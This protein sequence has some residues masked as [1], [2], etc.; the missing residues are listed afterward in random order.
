MNPPFVFGVVPLLLGGCAAPADPTAPRAVQAVAPGA[1][2]APAPLHV[3]AVRAG[4]PATAKPAR[5]QALALLRTSRDPATLRD[6]AIAFSQTPTDADVKILLGFLTD[7]A[8]L[9]RLDPPQGLWD[10]RLTD[11]LRCIGRLPQRQ[12][13][14]ALLQLAKHAEFMSHLGRVLSLLDGLAEIRDPS[15]TLL[16][17]LEKPATPEPWQ[18]EMIV[19]SG[20]QVLSK[21]RSPAACRRIDKRYFSSGH[22]HSTWFT[23]Y[24]LLLRDDPAIV[25][26]YHTLLSRGV[27]DEKLRNLIVESLF[28]YRREWYP[29]TLHPVPRPP[30]RREASPEGL[31]ELLRVADLTDKLRLSE[32][33]KAAVRKARA[34]IDEILPFHR[35]GKPQRIAQLIADLDHKQHSIRDKASRELEQFGDWAAPAIRKALKAS[36]PPSLERQRRLQQILTAIESKKAE[37]AP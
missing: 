14:S 6:A 1:T 17:F 15:D 35:A 32:D 18:A 29:R 7:P 33:T 20:F 2:A 34:E 24:L 11:V 8:F 3:A 36:P 12:A 9:T 13:N 37:K 4:Q 31:T 16:D 10:L 22:L 30:P 27:Q 26:M 21:M 5:E 28:G 25:A 23:W 19:D